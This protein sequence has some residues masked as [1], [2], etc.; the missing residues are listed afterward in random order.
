[1]AR[2][3]EVF[4][5]GCPICDQA[6]AMVRSMLCPSCELR[7][8]DTRS[9]LVAARARHLGVQRLPAIAVDGSLVECCRGGGIDEK[10]LRAAGIGKP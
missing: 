2:L 4:S 9:D 1:M 10:A 7:V 8:L 6:V 5:A 3:I